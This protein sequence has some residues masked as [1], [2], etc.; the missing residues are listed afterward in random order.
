MFDQTGMGQVDLKALK[1]FEREIAHL[2]GQCWCVKKVNVGNP[3]SLLPTAIAVP[4]AAEP[5]RRGKPES[6]CQSRCPKDSARSPSGP[7][8]SS[9]A[10]GPG[11]E[12]GLM[13]CWVKHPKRPQRLEFFP[14]HLALS[15]P[16]CLMSCLGHFSILRWIGS[17]VGWHCVQKLLTIFCRLYIKFF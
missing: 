4:E 8:Y 12:V 13:L 16:R 17:L 1:E 14:G 11:S 5:E 9:K 3:K 7:R 10:A 6:C 15:S 2:E